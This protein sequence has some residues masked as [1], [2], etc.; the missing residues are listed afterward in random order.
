[1]DFISKTQEY[2]DKNGMLKEED[3]VLV[4]VSGGMDS[5]VLL[6]VLLEL[7]PKYN[8]KISVA[9]LNHGIRG[10]EA[11]QDEKFVRNIAQSRGIHFFNHKLNVKG[12]AK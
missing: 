12:E 10:E 3:A 4:G 8:L 9:H 11:D 2:I 5:I 6:N 7:K 1:M